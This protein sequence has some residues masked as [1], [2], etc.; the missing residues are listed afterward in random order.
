M[1]NIPTIIYFIFIDEI[2]ALFDNQLFQNLIRFID[3]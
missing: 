2:E 3:D 1:L